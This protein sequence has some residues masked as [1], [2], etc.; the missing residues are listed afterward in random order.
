[1]STDN[2]QETKEI[3]NTET[4]DVTETI[5][6]SADDKIMT[7]EKITTEAEV[8]VEECCFCTPLICM[9]RCCASITTATPF[10]FSVS[11]KQSFISSVSRSCTCNLL[12]NTS[13]ILGILLSP[14]MCP[15]GM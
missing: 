2:Q 7:E 1:M 11:W 6:V 9:Q 12:E 10:G 5:P 3:E 13:T 15:F 4:P 14:T 8:V